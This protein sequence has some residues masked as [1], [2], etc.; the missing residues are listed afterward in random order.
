[1][2]RILSAV[3]IL[4]VLISIL[5][6]CGT[7]GSKAH[8]TK[9]KEVL[10]SLNAMKEQNKKP[11]E[12]FEYL[13]Q[14]IKDMNKA[15]ASEA[16]GILVNTLEEYETLYNEQLFTGNIPDLMYKY[17]EITFDYSKIESVKEP[18]LK[19]LLYDI[20]LGGFKIV[21]T[22]GTFMVIVDYD[23]LKTFSEYVDEEIINYI[24]IMTLMYGNPVGNDTGVLVSP[25]ELEKRILQMEDYIKKYNNPQRNEIVLSLYQGTIMVY[26]SGS[27]DKPIF[28][29]DTGAMN[30]EIF[31]GF[32]GAAAKYKDT[33]FSKVISKYVETLKQEGFVNTDKVQDFILN[34]DIIVNEELA[35][36]DKK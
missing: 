3:L 33:I 24:D 29:F 23:A 34:I 35:K 18:E 25:E 15:A 14:N 2:K 17:F 30:S 16:T 28:D 1:M 5:S 20:T 13:N 12:M 22:E 21:D 26:M 8:S 36:L 4:A 6:G 11:K 7:T 19:A 10:S 31:K 9:D 32:E 27:E